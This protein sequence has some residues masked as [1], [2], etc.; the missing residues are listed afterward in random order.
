MMEASRWYAK[1]ASDEV[2]EAEKTAWVQWKVADEENQLAWQ[3]LEGVNQAFKKVSPK[4]AIQTLSTPNLERRRAIKHL[5]VFL[6]AGTV[7]YYTYN[8]KPWRGYLADNAT[9]KGEQKRLQL[10]DGTLIHLNTDTAANVY[11]TETERLIELVKG[12]VFIETGHEQ[13]A[14][15]RPFKIRTRHGIAQ[16]LGTKFAVRDFNTH[17]KVSV[18]EGAVN[19][20]PQHL[21]STAQVLNQG[22]SVTFSQSQMLLTSKARVTDSAWIRGML[23]AYAMPLSEFLAELT[24][25]RTGVLRCHPSIAN[26]LISGSFPIKDSDEVINKISQILPVQIETYTRYWI[27]VNPAKQ[28]E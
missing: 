25:Y 28:T 24:R 21:A 26:L 13:S 14:V 1:L 16:A 5:A 22:E 4:I 18:F 11:F 3:R 20:K 9:G 2:T 7:S 27:N 23:V 8:E 15:Y 10:A 6:A 12:E 17:S 19:V